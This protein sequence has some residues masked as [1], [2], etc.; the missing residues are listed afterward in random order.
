MMKPRIR[1]LGRELFGNVWECISEQCIGCGKTPQE[2]YRV[3]LVM[4]SME[5]VQ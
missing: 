4:T 5:G 1:K 2:A 3:W